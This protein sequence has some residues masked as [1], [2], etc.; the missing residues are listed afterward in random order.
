VVVLPFELYIIND[1][2]SL[3]DDEAIQV[4]VLLVFF[5]LLKNGVKLRMSLHVKLTNLVGLVNV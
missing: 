4:E 5:Y 1:N 3:A 2:E